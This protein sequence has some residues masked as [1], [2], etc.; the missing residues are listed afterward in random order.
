MYLKPKEAK[1]LIK[2][3][4][5]SV[6]QEFEEKYEFMLKLLEDDDWSFVIK[7]HS[8]IESLVSELIITKIDESDLKSL[9]ERTPL[10][11]EPVSKIAIVKI[12]NLVPS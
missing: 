11:G 4:T 2:E 5:S 12:Y 3:L 7:S 1:K 10:H 6:S 9:I 8:L